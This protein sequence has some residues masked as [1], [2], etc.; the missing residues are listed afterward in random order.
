MALYRA[1]PAWQREN[2]SISKNIVT[3]DPLAAIYNEGIWRLSKVS[4]LYNL[5]YSTVK[6]KQY[7]SKIRQTLVSAMP[8]NSSTKYV[9]QIEEQVNLKYSEDDPSA[10]II[11]VLSSTQDKNNKSKVSYAA[12]LLSWGI[13]I[14]VDTGTHLPYMLERGE[15]RISNA[16][17]T[18]LQT[19]FDCQI[20]QFSFTQQ[21]LLY[22][23]FNFVESDSSRSTDPFTLTYKTPQVDHKDK[24]NLSFEVGDIQI[25]CNGI[26][27][28]V[29]KK[30]DLVTL[31][32]QI[33][34]NQIF[35]SSLVDIT[36][37][38]LCE[39]STP[40]AE[41]KNS[42]AVKMKTPDIVNCVFTVLNDISHDLYSDR[43]SGNASASDT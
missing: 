18:T 10:L 36:T 30:S 39:V 19:I 29:S 33:L 11:N 24:L 23:G 17:R 6:L 26:K 7:A 27:E 28:E 40:R 22:L 32:Y 34:Q 1:E 5:Q 13:N 20:K 15:Q 9:V 8:A 31:V 37:F 2:N 16:V 38:D 43:D 41:V 21:Q 14:S 42:G 3:G 12:I 25:I 35:D 4:P